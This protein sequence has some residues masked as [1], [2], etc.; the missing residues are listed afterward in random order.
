LSARSDLLGNYELFLRSSKP[1]SA[2]ELQALLAAV[3]EAEGSFSIDQYRPE[4]DPDRLLGIDL[5]VTHDAYQGAERL[6]D[7][8]FQ[9]A[10]DHHL[11]VFDPQLGRV[12]TAADAPTIT[13]RYA[14]GSAFLMAVPLS[15]TAEESSGLTASGKLW[16]A[17]AGL[18]L[19]LLVLV[20]IVHCAVAD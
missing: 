12:V 7:L 9:L 3:D 11:T 6:C 8:A 13:D 17:I 4:G 10:A 20:R 5:G 18:A 16:L 15:S 14:Q 19:G 2:D 1:L